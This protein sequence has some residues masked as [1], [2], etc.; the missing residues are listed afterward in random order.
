MRSSIIPTAQPR[1]KSFHLWDLR[2]ETFEAF[3][4]R[5]VQLAKL[6]RKWVFFVKSL[7]NIV[8]CTM[9]FNVNPESWIQS[10]FRN[11]LLSLALQAFPHDW[12]WAS[13]VSAHLFT[14]GCIVWYPSDCNGRRIE[15]SWKVLRMRLV[16]SCLVLLFC[17]VLWIHVNFCLSVIDPRSEV[18]C[19]D[20][21][22]L[23][24][25]AAGSFQV[26][27]KHTQ[28]TKRCEV[29]MLESPGSKF[30]I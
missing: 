29:G 13:L 17:S 23:S 30:Q 6:F 11:V 3:A 25:G 12:E 22:V 4:F 8:Q 24:Q 26:R 9:I 16:L 14:A 18:C 20:A 5:T 19:L 27:L 15:L 1:H 2:N 28:A 7:Y 21:A 10:V